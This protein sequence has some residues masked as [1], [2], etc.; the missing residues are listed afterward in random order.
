[1]RARVRARVCDGESVSRATDGIAHRGVEDESHDEAVQP[2]YDQPNIP[3]PRPRRLRSRLRGKAYDDF[4]KKVSVLNGEDTG[5]SGR[6]WILTDSTHAK[7]RI[8]TIE[9]NTRDSYK[10]ART[11]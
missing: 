6:V 2:L 7:I 8:R 11:H 5:T 1:M 4:P 3:T 10:Y 9:T